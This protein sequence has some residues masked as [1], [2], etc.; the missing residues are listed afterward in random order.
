MSDRAEQLS[1][2]TLSSFMF[3]CL[4]FCPSF[5]LKYC[6]LTSSNCLFNKS[7]I[8]LGE[9][10]L[11]CL[12]V[13]DLLTHFYSNAALISHVLERCQEVF[14]IS[15]W[16]NFIFCRSSPRTFEQRFFWE[17][18]FLYSGYSV[19]HQSIFFFLTIAYCS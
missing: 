8:S 19:L 11:W 5:S 7:K 9:R 14:H 1:L 17:L 18:Y 4:W 10:I 6:F 3:L 12:K 2:R 15:V 13:E 16:C